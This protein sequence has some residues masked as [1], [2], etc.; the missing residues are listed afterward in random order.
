MIILDNLSKNFVM[1]DGTKVKVIDNLSLKIDNKLNLAIIGPNGAGKSTLM[2]LISGSLI[3]DS[4]EVRRLSSVSWRVGLRSGFNATMNAKENIIFVSRLHGLSM[5]ETKNKIDFVEQFTDLGIFFYEP[6]NTYSSGM[7]AKF[8]F[9]MSMA[10]DFDFYL[11]DEITSVGDG[12]FR[13]K[14]DEIFAEKISKSGI[15][16]VSHNMSIIK[17]WCKS[18]LYIERGI[19]EFYE[20]IDDGIE[21]YKRA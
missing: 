9:A 16:M 1:R 17:K 15:I 8:G 6:I 18:A 20:N 19:C 21:R 7:G 10:F 11:V 12:E 13:K 5:N 14:A 2:S 3:P 4:G